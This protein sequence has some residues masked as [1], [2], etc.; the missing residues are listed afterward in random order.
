M[1]KLLKQKRLNITPFRLEVLAIFS[2]YNSAIP[3]S[4]VEKELKDYN[5]I[6]LYRTIKNFLAKGIIHEI[7]LSGEENNFAICADNC[8]KDKHEHKHIHFKCENCKS[9]LCVEV[10]NFP[11]IEIPQFKI[12]NLEI[13]ASGLCSSC[14]P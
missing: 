3:L 8:G 12:Q 11:K 10:D 9:V 1:E 5:R 7:A 2:K 6:T 13:Q 4:V 14:Q